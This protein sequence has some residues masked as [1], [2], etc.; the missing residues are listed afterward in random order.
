MKKKTVKKLVEFSRKEVEGIIGQALT[1]A[2][3]EDFSEWAKDE[4]IYAE[5][6]ELIYKKW[7][8]YRKHLKKDY[9][10]YLRTR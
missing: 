2:R 7:K 9:V 8:T 4:Q 5:V 1:T 10:T 6:E 3:F